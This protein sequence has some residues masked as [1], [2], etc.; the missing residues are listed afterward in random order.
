MG[1]MS[2]TEAFSALD[3]GVAV[4]GALDFDAMPVRERLRLLERLETAR[5]RA[6]AC[7]T[8]IAA[9]IDRARDPGVGPNAA[10]V[11]ADVLRISPTD[12]RR[13]LR[14]AEQLLPR[15]GL[16]GQQLPPMLPATAKAWDAGILDIAHLRV[17]QKFLRELPEDVPGTE[18]EKAEQFLAEK[19][20][21][22]RP[23]QLEVLADRL[24]LT[25]NPDGKFSDEY[26]AAQRTFGWCGRQRSDGMSVGRLV[27]T[28]ELRA[29]IDALLAKYAAP[30]MCNPADQSP[31]VN[32]E[33]SPEA[34]QADRRLHGQRQHDALLALLR[35]QLG[36]PA[37]G[38]HNGLPV[39]VVVSTTLDQL[40]SGAGIAVTG[41]G[42]T[43]P[44][45]DVI[46]LASHAWHYLVVY[47]THTSRPIYLGRTKRIATGDQRI[48]LHERDVGCTKPGCSAPGYITEVHHTDEWAAGGGT[49]VDKL[50]LACPPDHR[51]LT[52]GG[53]KARIVN[54][55]VEWIPP[56]Q[57]PLRGGT[58]DYHHPDRLLPE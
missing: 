1:S 41:G 6:A 17:I 23:D 57:L 46:R 43:L 5:R 10:K 3:A 37:L 58:N 49:D 28:P 36:S 34:A 24:A 44:M 18:V 50:I 30:G 53:W 20:A 51:L 33:P 16:T 40:H 19:A 29:A 2:A 47:D 52:D 8:E 56:P 39:T 15:T 11:I 21:E 45:T 12:A 9:S 13:R 42:S 38:R 31:T 4:V 48:V 54:G 27:A 25:L 32:G 35:S 14:D 26:R 55:T 22:L 7:A